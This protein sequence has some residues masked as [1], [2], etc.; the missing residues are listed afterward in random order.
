ML[1]SRYTILTDDGC[2]IVVNENGIFTP[3]PDVSHIGV[4]ES[5]SSKGICRRFSRLTYSAPRCSPYNWINDIMAVGMMAV[6][7]GKVVADAY[8]PTI[9]PLEDVQDVFFG[10]LG[11]GF[12]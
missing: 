4:E 2:H 6:W 12:D 9:A 1:N 5:A 11:K 10:Q 7:D 8:R 3:D